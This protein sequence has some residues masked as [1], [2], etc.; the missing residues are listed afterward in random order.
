MQEF[1]E[2][3]DEVQRVADVGNVPITTWPVVPFQEW[4]MDFEA[5]LTPSEALYGNYPSH[6]PT[7]LNPTMYD[8]HIPMK[9]R[10]EHTNGGIYTVL[11]LTN[12][13]STDHRRYPIYVV[14][15]GENGNRWTRQAA[16]WD[17]SMT[18][19]PEGWWARKWNEFIEI[20]SELAP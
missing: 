1:K 7:D 20:I 2:W 11:Y 12:R 3:Y 9:S 10:W 8:K 19:I 4:Y 17:R 14:Y 5:G 13:Y 18:R 15:R 16:D 6:S